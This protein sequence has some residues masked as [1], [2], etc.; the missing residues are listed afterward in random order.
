MND[1]RRRKAEQNSAYEPL[2]TFP[3]I[4]F[5]CARMVLIRPRSI[6]RHSH[7]A[8]LAIS[9]PSELTRIEAGKRNLEARGLRVTLADNIAH[10]GEHGYLAGS[11]DERLEIVNRFLRDPQYDGFLFARGG[12]GAMRI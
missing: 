5:E 4:V 6:N 11:D 7:V 8:V 12:Y 1:P 3:S 2:H 9:S 10:A